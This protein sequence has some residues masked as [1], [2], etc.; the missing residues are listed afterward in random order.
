[1]IDNV[2][3]DVVKLFRWTAGH[4]NLQMINFSG[5][6]AFSLLP[7]FKQITNTSHRAPW[8]P[9]DKRLV[10]Q[11]WKGHCWRH[12]ASTQAPLP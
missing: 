7:G 1:M 4:C 2:V 11:S 12:D 8:W 10:L 5:V 6:P 9:C 3:A